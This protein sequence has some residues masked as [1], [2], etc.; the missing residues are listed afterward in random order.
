MASDSELR[1]LRADSLGDVRAV[2][3][4]DVEAMKGALAA[5]HLPDSIVIRW[6]R[7]FVGDLDP[8]GNVV[9]LL[10]EPGTLVTGSQ[11]PVDRQP[12]HV[13]ILILND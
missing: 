4:E 12:Y 1:F 10:G 7:S 8:I 3:F 11:Q 13:T 9:L 2:K 6:Y 5:M